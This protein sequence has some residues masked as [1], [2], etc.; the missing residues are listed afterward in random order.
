MST[1]PHIVEVALGERSY[2]IEIGAGNLTD[3]PRLLTESLA[4]R[5]AK[6]SRVIVIT[7]D[8]VLEPHA[9]PVADAL[10]DAGFDVGALV[11]GAGEE[12]KSA[13][14]AEGLWE[15]MLERGADRKTVV[16]AIGV[17]SGTASNRATYFGVARSNSDT[18][19]VS[20]TSTAA[21]LRRGDACG[22]GRSRRS[23][24]RPSGRPSTRR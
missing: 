12:S 11:I 14:V 20:R 16:V 10:S 17:S 5:G 24:L 2:A 4:R 1:S 18:A 23:C 3:A 8:N 21:T 9:T 15:A 7:D 22:R 13:E 6:A 19:L